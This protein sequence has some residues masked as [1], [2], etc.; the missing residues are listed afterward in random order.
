MAEKSRHNEVKFV[1]ERW[2]KLS[3][4]AQIVAE[5]VAGVINPAQDQKVPAYWDE[6]ADHW[7]LG[8]SNDWWMNFDNETSE[9]KL[10]YRYGGTPESEEALLS[11]AKYLE[12]AL[13]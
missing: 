4:R 12:W 11:L 10:R 13:R 5:Y 8:N 6:R 2:K 1:V 9:V 3:N 7:Q